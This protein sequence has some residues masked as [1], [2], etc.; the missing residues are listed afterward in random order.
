[1]SA[2]AG[3]LAEP[4][5]SCGRAGR[6]VCDGCGVYCGA[7]ANEWQC[8]KC[9]SLVRDPRLTQTVKAVY[10]DYYDGPRDAMK[11]PRKRCICCPETEGHRHRPYSGVMRSVDDAE[12]D[13]REE[14]RRMAREAG[15]KDGDEIEIIVRKTGARP[16]GD[17][18]MCLVE[19]HTYKREPR[20]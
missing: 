20:Q 16:F 14:V 8:P 12:I 3:L 18:Q 5:A 11:E 9:G 7:C 4:C 6:L 10:T 15:V 2:T 1:M 13:V 17:R 19:P